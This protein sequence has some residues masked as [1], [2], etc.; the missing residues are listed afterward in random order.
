[1]KKS[2]KADMRDL[3]RRKGFGE[4][5]ADCTDSAY[6]FPFYH[7]TLDAGFTET[8]SEKTEDKVKSTTD[9]EVSCIHWHY[10][11]AEF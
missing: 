7:Q 2:L 11:A 4:L 5:T 9:C 6:C 8:S 1:M 3:Y 10:A